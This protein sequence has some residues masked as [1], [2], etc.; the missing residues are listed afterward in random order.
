M[1]STVIIDDEPRNIKLI[2]KMIADYCPALEVVGTC[3]DLTEARQVIEKHKPALLLLDIE[4]PPGTVFSM[5][6]KLVYRDFQIVFITAYNNY[7]SEA[8]REHASGY[9]LKPVTREA[10]IEAVKT[11]EERIHQFS[12]ADISKLV[13]LLKLRQQQSGKI[14]LPSGEGVLFVDEPEIVHCE[15]SG[16]YTIIHLD[17]KKKITVSKTLKEIEE[18]LNP[19][20]FFR[21]HHSH[22]INLKKISKF[23]R[24]HGGSVELSDSSVINVS[25]GRKEE[26]MHILM[27][28]SGNWLL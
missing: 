25:A 24:A 11:V 20:Q 23:H 18:L 21:V 16:R 2:A 8:Y 26:L 15:A 6:E 12:V 19:S 27:K 5:L 4:F 28:R 10:L 7:A 9:L 3:D 13:E 14:P 22:V 1:I 17:S